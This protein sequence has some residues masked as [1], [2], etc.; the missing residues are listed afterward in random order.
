ML[1]GMEGPAERL[2]SSTQASPRGMRGQLSVY[3]SL[4]IF[5][6][7][8]FDFLSFGFLFVCLFQSLLSTLDI[9]PKQVKVCS[10]CAGLLRREVINESRIKEK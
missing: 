4:V 8:S 7:F 9:L 2:F 6:P 1:K 3:G 5:F 10:L